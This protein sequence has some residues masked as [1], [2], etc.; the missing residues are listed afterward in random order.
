[1]DKMLPV[2]V[3][4]FVASKEKRP[5]AKSRLNAH[6]KYIEYRKKSPEETKEDRYIFSA[7]NDHVQRREVVTD[8]MDHTSYSALYHKIVLTPAEYEH[9]EDYRQWTRDIMRDLQEH[10]GIT[11]HWYAVVQTHEREN[12][13]APHVHIVLAGAGEAQ[14]TGNKTTVRMD[15]AKDYAFMRQSGR[16]HSDYEF[17]R[18]LQQEWLELD[19]DIFDTTIQDH[20]EEQLISH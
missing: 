9:V 8:I 14:D 1:M 12:I 2:V 19:A 4:K 17:Y 15:A 7:D 6:I 11:L 10:K 18:D 16:D 5:A 13:N 20:Q 3:G